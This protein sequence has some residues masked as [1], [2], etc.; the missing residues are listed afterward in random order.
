MASTGTSD[1]LAPLVGLPGVGGRRHAGPRRARRPAQPPRQPARA[2]RRRPPRPACGPPVRRPRSTA[3]RSTCRP[4]HGRPTRCSPVRSAPPRRSASCSARGAPRRC[5]RWPGCTSWPRPTS[6]PP[7][8]TTAS[9]AARDGSARCRRGW[10]CWPTCVT[11]G[12]RVPAPVLVAVV[13]GELLALRPF[14]SANGV[15]ARAAARLTAVVAGLDPHGLAVPEV[16]H[17][18]AP[19]EY[20]D[21]AA[22]FAAGDRRRASARGSCTAARSGRPGSARAPSIADARS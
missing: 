5:R 1:P 13:H 12:T 15:V 17:L 18:R 3:R 16:G 9:S 8:A 19:A 7:T 4:G 2:G 21:A 10:R 6:S 11:G 20:R 14:P 22:A